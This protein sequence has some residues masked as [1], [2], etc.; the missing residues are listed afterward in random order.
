MG[1]G[2]SKNVLPPHVINSKEGSHEQP[3][4]QVSHLLSANTG[5][6][7]EPSTLLTPDHFSKAVTPLGVNKHNGTS[8]QAVSPP[9]PVE[10]HQRIPT[11]IMAKKLG[12]F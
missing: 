12:K 3:E 5:L 10:N 8:S 1:C 2:N 7:S 9:P 6:K 4:K 11:P